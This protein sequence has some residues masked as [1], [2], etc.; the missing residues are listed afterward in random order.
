[1]RLLP[2]LL[3]L[4]AIDYYA[5]QAIQL[6][7]EG[8]AP[9]P[10]NLLYGL[11]WGMPLVLLFWTL[12]GKEARKHPRWRTLYRFVRAFLI[13]LYLAKLLVAAVV[14]MDDIRRLAVYAYYSL[15]AEEIVLERSI[16][17]A[18]AALTVGLLPLGVLTYGMLRN[19]YR[20]QLREQQI[21]IPGLADELKGLVLVQISDIHAGSFTRKD[22]LYRAIEL[23]NEQSADFVFFT[24]DLVNNQAEE[25]LPYQSIFEAIQ[26]RYGVY[27]IF[28][29]HDYG[30]Y[31]AWPTAEAKTNNLQRLA[32]AHAEMGWTLLRNQHRI[33][34][35]QGRS[36]AIIGV[37][38]YSALP[39]FQR[40]G[41]LD[42]AY[43]G[44]EPADLKILLSHDPTHWDVEVRPDFPD[45][46]L[47]FSGHTHGMQF[48]IELAEKFRWSPAQYVYKQWAGLYQQGKQWLYVNRGFGFLG[49]PGRVGILPEITRIELI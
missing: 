35:I 27:S 12:A 18:R 41:R 37:E 20:Y 46:A 39:R 48:G 25:I 16:W 34:D 19:P 6:L 26:A 17:M 32:T 31:I 33:I 45:I 38:N 28:G 24:G 4:L 2:L 5:F 43:A 36:L 23:I 42:E 8:L 11:Y 1:M 29:N 49:Y 10:R 47:T 3:V 13:I 40:Y 15:L 44:C 22:G 21:Q 14:L 9:F 7:T 30:D